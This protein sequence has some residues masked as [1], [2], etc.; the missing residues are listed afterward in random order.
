MTKA[1]GILL[2]EVSLPAAAV[3]LSPIGRF[4]ETLAGVSITTFVIPT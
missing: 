2:T 4:A 3:G 1:S